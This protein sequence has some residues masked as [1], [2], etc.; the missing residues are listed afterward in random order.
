M[1][2]ETEDNWKRDS[3]LKVVCSLYGA[4]K[5]LDLMLAK[6]EFLIITVIYKGTDKLVSLT[7]KNT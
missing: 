3:L 4:C 5:S 6:P 7:A 2:G 1:R